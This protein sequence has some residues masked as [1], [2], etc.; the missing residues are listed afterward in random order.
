MLRRRLDSRL[1]KRRRLV[2]L[3]KLKSVR[4]MRPL[5]ESKLDRKP[6]K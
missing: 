1:S 6:S 5:Q 2:V 4:G 3:L